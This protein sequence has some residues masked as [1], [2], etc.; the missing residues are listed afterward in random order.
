MPDKHERYG[1]YNGRSGQLKQVFQTRYKSGATGKLWMWTKDGS[2][3][4]P[5]NRRYLS[6]DADLR[7]VVRDTPP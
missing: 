5:T 3:E 4:S 1:Y 2:A 7:S 6:S